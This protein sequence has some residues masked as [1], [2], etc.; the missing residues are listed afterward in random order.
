ME[1][2]VYFTIEDDAEFEI[3]KIKGSRFIGRLYHVTT[4]EEAEEKL[5]A[6][7]KKFYDATHN[8]F[9]YI[10][11]RNENKITR[12]SDDGEPSGTAGKPIMAVLEGS[13]LT[14]V[15]CVVTR[16]YGGTK[17]G[18]GGLIRAYGDGAKGVLEVAKVKTVELCDK[19]K[20]YYEYDYT[21][22]VMNMLSAYECKVESEDYTDGVTVVVKIN[23]AFSDKFIEEIF[24]KS[25]GKISAVR[26]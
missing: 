6:V 24:D 2:K 17:L 16:Y 12:Y 1:K 23:E 4:K 20:F 15:L 18:T 26:I 21:N 10:T 25:N 14:D 9:A 11:G 22:L 13:G 8:C 19:L 3:E 5:L 7:K